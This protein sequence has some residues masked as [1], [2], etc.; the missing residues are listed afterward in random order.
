MTGKKAFR[1]AAHV[2]IA[3]LVIWGTYRSIE[4]SAQQLQLQRANLQEQI[5]EIQ[6]QPPPSGDEASS[7]EQLETLARLTNQ[8]EN[9]WQ[10]D[11]RYLSL[12]GVVYSISLLISGAYW[13]TCL[14]AM[15]QVVPWRIAAWAYLYG[16]LGKYVPGKAM[17][18]IMRLACLAPWGVRKV[19]TTLTIFMET[20]TSMAV[21]GTVAAFCVLVLNLDW[22][23][24][25]GA[26]AMLLC[27]AIPTA[28]PILRLVLR[29]LQSGVEPARLQQWTERL[30]W[31]LTWKGWIYLGFTWIGF[32]LSLGCVLYGLPSVQWLADSPIHFWLSVFA[33]CGLSVVAGF[34]SFTPS[35]AGV[36][37][38]VIA[39]VLSPIVGPTAALSCAIWLRITWVISDIIM[40]GLSYL[41]IVQNPASQETRAT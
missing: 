32:G 22:R 12:A 40:A 19:A 23:I 1:I 39:A 7:R 14:R 2:V 24:S 28:P 10:A 13:W 27:T 5:R 17:L 21:G 20:L 30:N 16:N 11:W 37:E 38:V 34:I 33:A 6:R 25:L 15:E 35:G 31:Q 41:L 9:Y 3:G 26:V 29:R 4:K 36:R 8:L 18:V